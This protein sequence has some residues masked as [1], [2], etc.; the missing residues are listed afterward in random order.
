VSVAR[1]GPGSRF[2]G[3]GVT[4]VYPF[5]RAGLVIRLLCQGPRVRDSAPG[6]MGGSVAGGSDG[7]R[8]VTGTRARAGCVFARKLRVMWGER[9]WQRR[10]S[11]SLFRAS[12]VAFFAEKLGEAIRAESV[13]RPHAQAVG[14][15]FRPCVTCSRDLTF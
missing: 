2:N 15:T 11:R 3:D 12:S 4:T 14:A 7:H 10:E 6:S 8:I 9:G 1:G 13:L 5:V